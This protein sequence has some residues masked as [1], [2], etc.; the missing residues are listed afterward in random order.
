MDNIYWQEIGRRMVQEIATHIRKKINEPEH[1]AVYK[2]Q[3]ERSPVYFID[4]EVEDLALA[5]LQKEQIP[6]VLKSED[7]PTRYVSSRPQKAFLLDPLDGSVNAVRGIPYYCVS[8]AIGDPSVATEFSL[9]KIEIGIVYNV[10]TMDTFVAI[11]NQGAYL[12]GN[13]IGPSH[14]MELSQSLI[15][16]YVRFAPPEALALANS[17]LAVRVTGSAA[18]ELCEVARG[19]YDAFVDVRGRL[20]VYDVA[21]GAFIVQESG[22]AI[23]VMQNGTTDIARMDR[24]NIIACNNEKLYNSIMLVLRG[25][26]K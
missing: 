8:L 18:L 12:N 17:A 4:K 22:G 10:C 3:R 25:N 23:S 21:A 11:K 2:L 1:I 20:K 24:V 5:L 19:T 26:H 13:R 6:V 7:S 15:A 16:M 14:I 9:E